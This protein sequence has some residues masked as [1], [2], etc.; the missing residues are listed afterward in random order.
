M[1][2]TSNATVPGGRKWP[3]IMMA[4]LVIRPN[5]K[6]LVLQIL[7]KKTCNDLYNYVCSFK[8]SASN[9]F[10]LDANI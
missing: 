5:G 10:Q 6:V 7:V 8:K 3:K 4:L 1:L 2:W 9:R